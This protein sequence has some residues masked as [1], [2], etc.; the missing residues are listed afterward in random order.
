MTRRIVIGIT[1][2]MILSPMLNF[3]D[4]S[5]EEEL[6]EEDIPME[7]AGRQSQFDCSDYNS[8]GG[9]EWQNN[10]VLQGQIYEYPA[11][12]GIYWMAEEDS[13]W[14]V[15]NELATFEELASRFVDQ[16]HLLHALRGTADAAADSSSHHGPE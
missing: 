5:T 13:N 2:L 16:G 15:G 11:G 10:A 6:I 3:A 12:S 4:F 7:T 9:P 1:L 14:P 8:Q